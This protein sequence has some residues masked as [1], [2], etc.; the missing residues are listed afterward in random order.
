[1][2]LV[3]KLTAL[4]MSLVYSGNFLAQASVEPR[5]TAR[6]RMGINPDGFA[7]SLVPGEV[8]ALPEAIETAARVV[9]H[10]AEIIR[11]HELAVRI[12]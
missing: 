7:W 3:S 8:L 2:I 1:M 6:L 5:G 9:L 11:V 10:V 4:G 12:E